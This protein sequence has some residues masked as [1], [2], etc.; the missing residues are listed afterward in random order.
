MINNQLP[1]TKFQTINKV[2]IFNNQNC[3][4]HWSFGNWNL[5]DYWNLVIG[6]LGVV[7]IIFIVYC[8]SDY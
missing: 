7:K 4:E 3:L 2:Q 6:H 1:M 8:L 5:F